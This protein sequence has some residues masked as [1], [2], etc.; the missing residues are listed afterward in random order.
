MLLPIQTEPS[1]PRTSLR[2]AGSRGIRCRGR[3]TPHRS[4][5]SPSPL[6]R[7][8]QFPFRVAGS[9]PEEEN[10]TDMGYRLAESRAVLRWVVYG[11]DGLTGTRESSLKR[12]ASLRR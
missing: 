1:Q 7:T 4:V 10:Q 12:T 2:L 9:R 8:H 5:V 3:R 11:T 6:P